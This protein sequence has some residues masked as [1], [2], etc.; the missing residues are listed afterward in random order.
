MRSFG[1]TLIQNS[2]SFLKEKAYSDINTQKGCHMKIEAE[3]RVICRQTKECQGSPECQ[4]LPE[5]KTEA[6]KRFFFLVFQRHQP[7]LTLILDFWPPEL[8]EKMLLLFQA[9]QLVVLCHDTVRIQYRQLVSVFLPKPMNNLG[10]IMMNT[11][12]TYQLG[13]ICRKSKLSKSL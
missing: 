4:G 3:I 7:Y 9:T 8:W 11:L 10:L 1:W 5:A 2:F 13:N 6:W 12:E